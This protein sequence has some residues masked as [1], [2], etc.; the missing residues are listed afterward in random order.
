MVAGL[1]TPRWVLAGMYLGV[2]W[3]AL[4][5]APALLGRF[6]PPALALL[7]GGGALYSLGA[8]CYA[9][10][11]PRLWQSVFGYHEVFHV[12]TIAAGV[13]FFLFILGYV[14]PLHRG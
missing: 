5:V 2:G 4:L 3:I 13:A 14:V 11:R 10:R 1:R 8:L 12:L 6:S 9:T 7:A